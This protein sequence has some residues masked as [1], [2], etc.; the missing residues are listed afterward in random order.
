MSGYYLTTID[1]SRIDQKI[2][3]PKCD[4]LLK[5]A[6]QTIACGH[7]YCEACVEDILRYVKVDLAHYRCKFLFHR[8]LLR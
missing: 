4:G 8:K 5:Q 6:V 7:R 2:L 1:R 3:C